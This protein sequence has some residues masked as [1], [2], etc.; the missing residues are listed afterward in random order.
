VADLACGTYK[1]YALYLRIDANM[2]CHCVILQE[3]RLRRVCGGGIS[4]LFVFLYAPLL[5]LMI[6][7]TKARYPDQFL[8]LGHPPH[9][10]PV[11]Q[12]Q[13]PGDFAFFLLRTLTRLPGMEFPVTQGGR[14]GRVGARIGLGLA[15]ARSVPA[16]PVGISCGANRC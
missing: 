5:P 15:D 14:S 6:I 7:M 1:T 4:P 3:A 8:E 16:E 2:P 13:Q 12:P 9:K 11:L 10:A